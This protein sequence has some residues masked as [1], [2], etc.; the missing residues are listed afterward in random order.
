M[1]SSGFWIRS[2]VIRI[3]TAL[4]MESASSRSTSIAGTGSTSSRM[5]PMTPTAKPT[6]PRASHDQTSFG[7]SL[8]RSVRAP[9]ARSATGGL[10]PKRNHSA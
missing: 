7:L 6:S 5:M 8:A 4:A 2:A 9:S 10:F 3:S 1:N